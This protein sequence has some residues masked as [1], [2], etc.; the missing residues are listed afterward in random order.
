MHKEGMKNVLALSFLI[1]HFLFPFCQWWRNTSDQQWALKKILQCHS[2]I[3]N[4]AKH[5]VKAASKVKFTRH[6][7]HGT[8]HHR[9]ASS[10]AYKWCNAN[11]ITV[12]YMIKHGEETLYIKDREGGASCPYFLLY[13]SVNVREETERMSGMRKGGTGRGKEWV[14]EK[15]QLS[16]CRAEQDHVVKQLCSLDWSTTPG[17]WSSAD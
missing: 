12:T 15:E 3:E 11:K 14:R 17:T 16:V 7:L 4:N 6:N 10:V 5:E 8:P 1:P 13:V 2:Q 9:Q